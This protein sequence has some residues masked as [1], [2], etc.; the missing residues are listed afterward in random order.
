LYGKDL[1]IL[2]KT[3]VALW[4]HSAG[5]RLLRIVL[6]RDPKGRRKDDGFFSTDAQTHPESVLETYALR[7]ALEVA[8]RD[9]KQTL[10]FERSQ[11][12]TPNA[13]QRSGPFA[14]VSY[15]LTVA[16]FCQYGYRLYPKGITL[17]PW[18]RQKR[19]PSFRDMLELLQNELREKDFCYTPAK[20]RVFKN[21]VAFNNHQQKRA[22]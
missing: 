11:A 2:Y 19:A 13:V 14:F 12:R 10:G 8:F 22:A 18:Y 4:Y 6:V 20:T 5:K 7:W 9:S 3:T 1:P 15:T 21:L 17:M 16:W